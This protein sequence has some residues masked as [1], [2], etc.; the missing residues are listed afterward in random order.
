MHVYKLLE[1]ESGKGWPEGYD[2]SIMEL[3]VQIFKPVSPYVKDEAIKFVR[4]YHID[5]PEMVFLVGED[6]GLQYFTKEMELMLFDLIDSGCNESVKGG[7]LLRLA[8]TYILASDLSST[9]EYYNLTHDEYI[10]II[11][12]DLEET[13]RPLYDPPKR[14]DGDCWKRTR[15]CALGILEELSSKYKGLIRYSGSFYDEQYTD[16]RTCSLG[17]AGKIISR[18]KGR[19]VNASVGQNLI[20][21]EIFDLESNVI[22]L[23]QLKGYVTLV[24][25]WSTNCSPCKEF[26]KIYL[27]LISKYYD[28]P[29]RILAF[30]VDESPEE[31]RLYLEEN[32]LPS[33]MKNY[34]VGPNNR[35]LHSW[36]VDSYPTTLLVNQEG[37]VTAR[38]QF[39]EEFLSYAI[40]KLLSYQ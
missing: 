6:L 12:P 13:M 15:R 26:R 10:K 11:V 20:A 38:D 1:E 14:W 2:D 19:V 35:V 21:P 17:K 4:K 29:F 7:A 5:D 30:N 9:L 16:F 39:N 27:S 37:V 24:Y 28:Y 40:D 25:I 23:E 3:V 31:L 22:S 34:Q 8:N 32:P 33:N 36:G 18:F